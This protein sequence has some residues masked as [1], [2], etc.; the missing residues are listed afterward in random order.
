[1]SSES[2]IIVKLNEVLDRMGRLEALLSATRPTPWPDR[3]TTQQATAYVRVAYGRPRFGGRTL[4]KW[5]ADGLLTTFK[6]CRWDRAELDR[7]LSGVP[8]STERR[9]RRRAD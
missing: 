6:P 7:I 9:G 3:L 8:V 2:A 4:R 1:M 5:R